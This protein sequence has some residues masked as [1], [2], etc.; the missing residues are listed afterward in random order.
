[1][2]YGVRRMLL[3][4]SFSESLD[5]YTN[6]LIRPPRTTLLPYQ[7]LGPSLCSY[8]PGTERV[9]LTARMLLPGASIRRQKVLLELVRAPPLP[10]YATATRCPVLTGLLQRA[11]SS[12][13]H[14]SSVTVA[15]PGTLVR[16]R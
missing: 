9:V 12:R 13:Q 3:P 16:A 2:A 5:A 1:M 6:R 10:S 4:G 15:K 14:G 11:N 8:A 7:V